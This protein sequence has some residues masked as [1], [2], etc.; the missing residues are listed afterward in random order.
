MP[1]SRR[2]ILWMSKIIT[3]IFYGVKVSDPHNGYRVYSLAAL[4]KITINAD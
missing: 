1:V 3:R 2:I 4:E